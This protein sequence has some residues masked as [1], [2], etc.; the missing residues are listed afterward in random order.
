MVANQVNMTAAVRLLIVEDHGVV[1]QALHLLLS[2]PRYGIE[3]VG[4]AGDGVEAMS[5]L[6]K[7][8]F[9]LVFTDI[10]MPNMN[11]IDLIQ[12]MKSDGKLKS[13]PVIILSAETDKD[14]IVKAVN[15]GVESYIIKPATLPVLQKKMEEAFQRKAS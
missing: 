5:H 4:E 2:D 13:T 15:M 11:G 12:K 9:G 8:N 3:V 6:G 1:R 7:K 14:M 10:V